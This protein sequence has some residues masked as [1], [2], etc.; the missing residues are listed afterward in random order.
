MATPI[1]AGIPFRAKIAIIARAC[2]CNRRT[3]SIAATVLGTWIPIVAVEWR[4]SRSTLPVEAL[5][6]HGAK[7]TIIAGCCYRK[8]G[9]ALVFFTRVSRAC[10][11]IITD[12]RLPAR[13]LS[14]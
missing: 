14:A 12:N 9:A 5:V 10:I 7:V 13:T 3:P 6:A 1:E 11:P 2:R 8:M 4:V